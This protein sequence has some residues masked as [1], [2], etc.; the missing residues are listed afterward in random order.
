MRNE[1]IVAVFPSRSALTKGL[2][3]VMSLKDVTIL[4]AAVVAKAQSGEIAIAGDE[5]STDEAGI[6]GGTLGAAIGVLGL[7]QM[8]ALALT[9]V[10]VIIAIGAGALVGGLLGGFTGRFAVNLLDSGAKPAQI[11][12]L[13]A[14]LQTGHCAIIYEMKPDVENL[15]RLR[16]ELKAYRVTVVEHWDNLLRDSISAA[17]AG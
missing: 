15:P 4:R 8:G 13:G 12:A 9:G 6:A 10:G 14:L 7:A 16:Q 1:I 11:Q 5:I 3:H 2:D 17:S